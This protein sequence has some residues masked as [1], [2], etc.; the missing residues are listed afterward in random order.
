MKTRHFRLLS[1]LAFLFIFC[2]EKSGAQTGQPPSPTLESPYNTMLVHLYYLQPESY[3]PEI[4]A[5][6]IDMPEDSLRAIQLAIQLKQVLDGNGLFVRLNML[7]QNADYQDSVSLQNY[8]TPFQLELPDVYLE[9][10]NGQWFYSS[11]TIKSIPRLHRELYPFGTD[12]LVNLFPE[13]A[14]QKI[15]GL[16]TW[17]WAG[18]LFLL[19]ASLAFQLLVSR[20]LRPLV[21]RLARSKYSQPLDDKK[22]LWRIAYL[23]SL[24]L[25]LILFRYALP[26]I[27]L[28]AKTMS[29][30][31][32]GLKIGGLF[33]GVWLLLSIITVIMQY[34]HRY[35]SSTDNRLDEQLIPIIRRMLKIV[36]VIGGIIYFLQ[37]L[38]VNVTAL[39]AGV[40]IGGLALALAAQDTVKNFIGSAMIFFDRPFQIGDWIVTGSIEGEVIEVGFR[41][42]RLQ[43]VDSS[44]MTV[45]NSNFSTAAITNLGMRRFRLYKTT[46]GLTYGTP[47]EK[48]EA[49]IARLRQ[50]IEEHPTTRKDNYLVH[51][52]NFGE[53]TL[54]IYFRTHFTASTF[55]EEMQTKEELAFSILRLAQEVGVDFA[56][57]TR[58]IVIEKES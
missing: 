28:S 19:L 17:Q 8:Y 53:S 57:P 9:K 54:D 52:N 11:Q 12:F 29:W 1:L 26:L 55:A 31:V 51:F 35:A 21:S 30:L 16:A 38:D 44:I 25:L 4:A 46:L 33:I 56:F 7:P 36:V 50:M 14:Q 41:S 27:Q 37:L 6:T 24:F 39:I 2:S 47:P 3:Q 40:S 32:L 18:I 49:F 20:L 5:R 22:L 10:K 58:T 45:P 34:A 23:T 43:T 15:L 42:T 13:G 48:I